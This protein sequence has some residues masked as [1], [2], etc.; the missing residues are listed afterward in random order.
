MISSEFSVAS[1]T[2]L[3]ILTS[4]KST[5]NS[6]VENDIEQA[7]KLR[8]LDVETPIVNEDFKRGKSFTSAGPAPLPDSGNILDDPELL[9]TEDT[10][11]EHRTREAEE[12]IRSQGGC[13]SDFWKNKYIREAGRYWHQFYKRNKDNFY[14]DRHYLHVVFPELLNGPAADS[15][16]GCYHLLEV[17]CG[18]GN[19]VLPLLDVNPH[20]RIHAI[21]FASSAIQI[22][23][24]HPACTASPVSTSSSSS[25][26][27]SQTRLMADVC[28][29][30]T[31][32]LPSHVLDPAVGG[33][34]A[35]LCM[36]VLSAI[37][38]QVCGTITI[39]CLIKHDNDIH[40]IVH[41]ILRLGG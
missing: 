22:L 34:D 15:T 39:L 25:S 21:D 37:G 7:Q 10:W 41:I 20:I 40:R 1:L 16:D 2:S 17:G 24:S 19:A 12:R 28:N 26:S 18:V 4:L 6:N 35:V 31:D 3:H 9:W 13:V 5:T 32:P 36:F 11:D 14:K 30:V 23:R 33:M 8:Q 38:P 27:S 29:V